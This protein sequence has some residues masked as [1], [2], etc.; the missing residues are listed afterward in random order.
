[1]DLFPS[2]Y[3]ILAALTDGRSSML[4][5]DPFILET[6]PLLKISP[7]ALG[8]GKGM[9]GILFCQGQNVKTY[10]LFCLNEEDKMNCISGAAPL[11]VSFVGQSPSTMK[12]SLCFTDWCPSAF[13]GTQ[14]KELHLR[15]KVF[16]SPK[17]VLS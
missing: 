8:Q 7:V 16:I 14:C 5:F 15:C 9:E 3:Y 1:M 4:F 10:G 11:T 13:C 12:T 2:G 6:S 17:W